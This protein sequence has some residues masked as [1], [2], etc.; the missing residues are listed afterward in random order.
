MRDSPDGLPARRLMAIAS[1]GTED[2]AGAALAGLARAL[3]VPVEALFVEDEDLILLAALPFT[4]EVGRASGIAR[5]FGPADLEHA[6][7][8]AA[9]RAEHRLRHLAGEHHFAWSFERRRGRYVAEVLACAR[10]ADIVVVPPR[11]AG[12]P[13]APAHGAQPRFRVFVPLG[14]LGPAAERALRLAAVLAEGEMS[15][16]VLVTTDEARQERAGVLSWVAGQLPTPT[17][18]AAP[19]VTALAAP[20][21]VLVHAGRRDVVVWPA[22][23]TDDAEPV[24]AT[25]LGTLHCTAVLVR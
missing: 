16:L 2:A 3:S 22:P 10:A 14:S 4:R 9:Q 25:I 15:R 12:A 5:E 24:L 20:D 7:R 11:L 13:S 8:G 23:S 6:M 19:I 21:A 17:G 1:L 18:A